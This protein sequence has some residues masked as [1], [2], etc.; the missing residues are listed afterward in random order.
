M[1]HEFI[2]LPKRKGPKA[3]TGAMFVG[4][5]DRAE[6]ER[7]VLERRRPRVTSP[8]PLAAPAVVQVVVQAPPG[9]GRRGAGVRPGRPRPDPD[10]GRL[11]EDRARPPHRRSAAES[12]RPG[13]SAAAAAAHRPGRGRN[14]DSAADRCG[15]SC[16]AE[17]ERLVAARGKVG[18]GRQNGSRPAVVNRRTSGGNR[19]PR[20]FEAR[21]LRVRVGHACRWAWRGQSLSASPR[22]C[23][24]TV[25]Q[26][27]GRLR[28]GGTGRAG[29][30]STECAT[31]WR[32]AAVG[33]DSGRGEGEER[34]PVHD[35]RGAG[36]RPGFFRP[37]S[38]LR[39][40]FF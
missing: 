39:P 4:S 28:N 33:P 19:S 38:R 2:D 37:V 16:G 23:A 21:V 25:P 40:R 13:P 20:G 5:P 34:I 14:G 17:E 36:E 32:V 1:V 9:P 3:E 26:N 35:R 27:P 18:F 10:A 29:I 31:G 7:A 22:G 12:R 6:A 24:S 15:G 8:V 30:S 11:P